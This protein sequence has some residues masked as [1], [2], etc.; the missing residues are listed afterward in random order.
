MLVDRNRAEHRDHV[1][2]PVVD[3]GRGLRACCFDR[4]EQSG[5]AAFRTRLL[6]S[7]ERFSAVLENVQLSYFSPVTSLSVISCRPFSQKG[8]R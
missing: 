1:A 2:K 4:E 3:A 6:P 5:A 8:G 7:S